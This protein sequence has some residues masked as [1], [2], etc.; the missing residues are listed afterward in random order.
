MYK[1]FYVL[2]AAEFSEVLNSPMG[3]G[4][5]IV[6]FA[7][8]LVVLTTTLGFATRGESRRAQDLNKE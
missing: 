4:L 3:T 6:F 1:M 5:V 8:A 2:F 7:S